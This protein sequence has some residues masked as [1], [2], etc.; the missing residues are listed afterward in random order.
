MDTAV[1]KPTELVLF[2]TYLTDLQ[3]YVSGG[4]ND[5]NFYKR[6]SSQIEQI[7]NIVVRL[8]NYLRVKDSHVAH[9][10]ERSRRHNLH[11]DEFTEYKQHIP[12]YLTGIKTYQQEVEAELIQSGLLEKPIQEMT[13]FELKTLLL[14]T[15]NEHQDRKN[16]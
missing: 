12:Y 9:Q 14:M 13:G 15:L 4:E 6:W 2:A 16:Q 1:I 11:S 3:T 10:V 8:D 7:T 5:R